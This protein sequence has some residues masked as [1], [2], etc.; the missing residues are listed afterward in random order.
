[1]H[2]FGWV[3][4]RRFQTTISPGFWCLPFHSAY[5][6]HSLSKTG[7]S[8]GNCDLPL[9]SL[10]VW[11]SSMVVS[12]LADNQNLRLVAYQ[13]PTSAFRKIGEKSSWG[14]RYTAL[15]PEAFSWQSANSLVGCDLFFGRLR[16]SPISKENLLAMG[17]L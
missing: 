1:M 12:L 3:G 13:G 10:R 8:A 11:P 7:S 2:E 15:Y 9:G 5:Q 17:M 6:E 16:S 14:H 4:D